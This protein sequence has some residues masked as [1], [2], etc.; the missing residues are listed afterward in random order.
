MTRIRSTDRKSKKGNIEDDSIIGLNSQ[1]FNGTKHNNN[2]NDVFNSEDMIETLDNGNENANEERKKR[3]QMNNDKNGMYERNNNNLYKES[4]KLDNI[5]GDHH[6]FLVYLFFSQSN[7]Y[8]ITLF[9]KSV[10]VE[11]V[12]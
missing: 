3:N 8:V 7:I 11:C 10:F 1:N 12:K 6:W 9:F 5:T 4:T 2:E